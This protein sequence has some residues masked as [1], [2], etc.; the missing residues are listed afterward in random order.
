M[1]LCVKLAGSPR[2]ENPAPV[3]SFSARTSTGR[4][5]SR[6]ATRSALPLPSTQ[7]HVWLSVWSPASFPATMRQISVLMV[8]S[9]P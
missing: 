7:Q 2:T 8:C 9:A 5:L 3:V 1:S 4:N 6:A